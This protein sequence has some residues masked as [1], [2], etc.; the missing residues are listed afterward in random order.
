MSLRE[1]IQK[2]M[3][4]AL[5]QGDKER[6][7]VLRM[8]RAA[9]RNAEIDRQHDLDDDEVVAVLTKAAKQRRESVEAYRQGGR[10]DL[11][12]AEEAEL[13]II[14]AYLPQQLSEKEVREIAAR[15]IAELGAQGPQDM[16]WV[17]KH[18]MG[19]LRGQADGR[20]VNAIVREILSGK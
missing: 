13:Q 4:D 18:L 16:G 19:Q 10:E 14:E 7:S 15:T 6:L 8:L 3:Q 20:L 9:V 1:R 5:R 17:M 12:V 11:A 2:D